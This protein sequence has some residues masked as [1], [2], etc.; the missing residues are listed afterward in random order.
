MATKL[1]SLRPLKI[2]FVTLRH[3]KVTMEYYKTKDILHIMKLLGHRNIRNALV[4][5][6]LVDFKED[7]YVRGSH[8][9]SRRH[10]SWLKLGS[11]MSATWRMLRSSVSANSLTLRVRQNVV[12]AP[13]VGFEP[14]GPVKGHRLSRSLG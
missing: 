13:G 2:T 9:R 6:H 3:L 14:T 5:T 7:E 8:G 1:K 4:Y 12:L 11:N 10:V